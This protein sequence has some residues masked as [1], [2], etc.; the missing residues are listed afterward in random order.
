[1]VLAAA[2]EPTAAAVQQLTKAT[3][4]AAQVMVMLA[5]PAKMLHIP[6][7][8]AVQAQPVQV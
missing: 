3:L 1:V 4:V 6:V 2:V 5:L 8:V 7:A